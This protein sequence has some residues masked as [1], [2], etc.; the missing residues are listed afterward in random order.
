MVR[1]FS[2]WRTRRRR[3][4]SPKS[5]HPAV[6]R[7]PLPAIPRNLS[8]RVAAG[9][10]GIIKGIFALPEIFVVFHIVGKWDFQFLAT[11][12]GVRA[13]RG[14][15]GL[16]SDADSCTSFFPSVSL[17]SFF[18]Y[19][20]GVGDGESNVSY[21]FLALLWTKNAILRMLKLAFEYF[22][23]PRRPAPPP[24]GEGVG[25]SARRFCER[26]NYFVGVEKSW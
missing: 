16:A 25:S 10:E 18:S 7:F 24:E 6:T 15:V 21:E 8:V 19:V 3:K 13:G 26:S 1:E 14:G 23:V 2:T 11:H 5:S 12:E 9:A 4:S 22:R 17:S 20:V